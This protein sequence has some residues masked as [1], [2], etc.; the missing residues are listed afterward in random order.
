M[1]FRRKIKLLGLSIYCM[2]TTFI[3]P[4]HFSPK[5]MLQYWAINVCFVLFK[6]KERLLVIERVTGSNATT[7]YHT[8]LVKLYCSYCMSL[9]VSVVTGNISP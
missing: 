9:Q 5:T 7:S 3:P 4:T 2:G 8:K 6:E 1:Y